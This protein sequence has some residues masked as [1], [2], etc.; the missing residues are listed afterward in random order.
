MNSGVAVDYFAAR[1]T[2]MNHRGY[3]VLNG[4]T[5][6][7]NILVLFIKKLDASPSHL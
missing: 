5:N 6:K 3:S 1:E 2:D 7:S 4:F